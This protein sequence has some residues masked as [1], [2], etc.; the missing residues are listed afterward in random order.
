MSTDTPADVAR[1]SAQQEKLETKTPLYDPQTGKMLQQYKPSTGSRIWRGVRGGLEGIAEHG[2]MGGLLG[3]IDP[4]KVTGTAYGAPNKQYTRA[5]D[6]REQQLGA[7]D[8]ELKTAM[9]T[10][11]DVNDARKAKSGEYRA[12]AT[13]GKDLVSGAGDL[14]K[15]SIDKFK[16]EATADNYKTKADEATA[17]LQEQ[18]QKDLQTAQ[19]SEE[20]IQLLTNNAQMM[21]Q[22]RRMQLDFA[23]DKLGT[24][25]DAKTVDGW[26]KEQLDSIN[27]DYNG[28]LSSAW[29]R[30]T[31]G[32]KQDR[33]AEINREA[34]KRRS[35]LGLGGGGAP[36]TPAASEPGSAQPSGKAVSLAA[37]RQLPQYRGKSD[38]E[39]TAAI[40]KFGHE[41]RP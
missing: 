28:I 16:A 23:K 32:S 27:K 29:N 1:L 17:K 11:K 33:I 38:A 15:N 10:W 14:Q 3:A 5:E 18:M 22:I 2:I 35:A 7:T 13:L 40:K 19:T 26:Q 39:I 31:A 30:M 41:V 6:A 36:P 24:M 34:D 20:R 8:N 37:A 25:T 4:E 9:Q 12:N 21:D